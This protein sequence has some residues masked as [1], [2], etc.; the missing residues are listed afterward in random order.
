[1]G[2][3]ATLYWP[4]LNP[5]GPRSIFAALV[6]LVLW[7]GTSE[8]FGPRLTIRR[9]LVASAP[10]ILFALLGFTE[11]SIVFRDWHGG[12]SFPAAD[13]YTAGIVYLAFG[14]GF[15]LQNFRFPSL[16]QRLNGAV[17]VLVYVWLTVDTIRWFTYLAQ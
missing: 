12:R 13:D 9:V 5:V 17:S 2:T 14:L 11:G 16:V 8:F 6:V 10:L 1:M 4:S 3:L 7:G 15:A